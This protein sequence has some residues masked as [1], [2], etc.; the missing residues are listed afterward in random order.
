V[1]YPLDDVATC[2]SVAPKIRSFPKIFLGTF[3][4]A[5]PGRVFFWPGRAGPVFRLDPGFRARVSIR[6]SIDRHV[7]LKMMNS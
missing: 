6:V 3:E 5:S 1:L 4:N 7:S 2:V